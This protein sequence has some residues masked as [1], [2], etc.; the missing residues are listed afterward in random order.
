MLFSDLGVDPA[1]VSVLSH[2]GY[3]KPT[4]VQEQ[5]IPLVLEGHDL[6]ACAQ[7]GTG[8]T[9]AFGVPIVQRLLT[10]NK[11]VR[12]PRI[13]VLV[14][15]RELAQ[16]VA[17]SFTSYAKG[18]SLRIATIYGGVPQSVQVKQLR[19]RPAII[20]ATPGRLLDLI[21]QRLVSLSEIDV[22]VLDEADRMLDMGFVKPIHE[23]A[24]LT[25][26]KRQ[27]LLF[28][29]TMP[30]SIR[31]LSRRLL[32]QPKNINVAPAAI[33]A[34]TISQNVYFVEQQEKFELLLHLLTDESLTRTIVFARTKHGANRIVSKL[35]R[36]RVFAEVIHGDKSQGARQ[37][38]L[39]NFKRGRATV[40]V[41]TDVAARGIDID[42]VTHIVNYDMPHEPDSYVHRIGR[43][44]RAGASGV[45]LSFCGQHERRHL[46]SIE[47]LIRKRLRVLTPAQSNAS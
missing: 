44:G 45:A 5:S 6:L 33:T 23:I 14:P 46:R 7:T 28:S 10:E 8:K 24:S 26:P 21:D 16:Q 32:R 30:T 42:T 18:T 2:L 13:L 20:C 1:L 25:S 29:A 39:A 19:A 43:T 34:D 37:Q 38:A 9:A 40:L 15:T 31:E 41:A 17:A 35:K 47:N 4:A 11:E 12:Q 27:T 22:L 36:A 3:Q